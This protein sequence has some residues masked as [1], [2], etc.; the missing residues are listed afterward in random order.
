MLLIYMYIYICS[1]TSSSA[2]HRANQSCTRS[3]ELR[4]PPMTSSSRPGRAKYSFQSMHAMQA[5]HDARQYQD[6]QSC[7]SN[8]P[9]FSIT[10]Q[11]CTGRLLYVAVHWLSS[12]HSLEQNSGV[13]GLCGSI[14]CMRAIVCMAL[15]NLALYKL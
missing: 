12:S 2:N 11:Y 10:L 7:A 14:V 6:N 9:I 5:Q 13:Q 4:S 1:Y 8:R 3:L 15:F